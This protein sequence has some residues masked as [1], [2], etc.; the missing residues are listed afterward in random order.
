M[1][2]G[3]AQIPVRRSEQARLARQIFAGVRS[4]SFFQTKTTTKKLIAMIG[5]ASRANNES[6]TTVSVSMEVLELSP[7]ETLVVEGVVEFI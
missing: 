7:E 2:N 3:M 5:I 1:T 4:I 6:S